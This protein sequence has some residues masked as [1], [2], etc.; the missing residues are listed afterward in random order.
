ML[1]QWPPPAWLGVVTDPI[2]IFYWLIRPNWTVNKCPVCGKLI[3]APINMNLIIHAAADHVAMYEVIVVG[4]NWKEARE[5][6]RDSDA[7]FGIITKENTPEAWK[8]AI[9][10][11]D[12]LAG[13]DRSK[14]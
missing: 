14:F 11:L 3:M 1:N 6:V 10:M 2:K 7:I 12:D 9:R 4:L 13:V 8:E 5:I